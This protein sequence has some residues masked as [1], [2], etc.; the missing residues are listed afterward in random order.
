M[1][2]TPGKPDLLEKD[3]VLE[4]VWW[5]RLIISFSFGTVAGIFNLTGFLVIFFYCSSILVLTYLYTLK[6]LQID[7]R[8]FEEQEIF[9]EGGGPSIAIFLLMWIITF[10]YV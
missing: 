1:G 6:F 5:L 8:E 9:M 3:D 2:L 10:N 4:L 7:D